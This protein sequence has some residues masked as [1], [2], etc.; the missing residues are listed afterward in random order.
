MDTWVWLDRFTGA[1]VLPVMSYLESASKSAI[2]EIKR[3]LFLYDFKEEELK[4][5]AI[6]IKSLLV[7]P[8]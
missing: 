3:L 2:S 8:S 7:K 6:I 4:E 5:L 1:K